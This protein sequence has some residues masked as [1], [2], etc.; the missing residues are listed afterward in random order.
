MSLPTNLT[1]NEVK[2][3]SGTEVEFLHQQQIGRKRILFV[4]SGNPSLA[5]TLTI[6]HL[7]VGV[8]LKRRVRSNIRIDKQSISTVDS[9]TPVTT[10]ASFVLDKPAG[11]ITSLNEPKAVLAEL[12][13]FIASLATNTLLYDGTGNGAAA[14]LGETL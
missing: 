3:A 14:L 9:I 4:N 8:G 12:T 2:D 11:A 1:T 7:E 10:I 6:Q 5:H 13:S